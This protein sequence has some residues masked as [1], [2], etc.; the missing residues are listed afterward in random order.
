MRGCEREYFSVLPAIGIERKM[1]GGAV[2]EGGVT[3]YFCPC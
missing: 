3:I 1:D 2:T